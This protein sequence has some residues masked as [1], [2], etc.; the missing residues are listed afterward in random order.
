MLMLFIIK[1]MNF[2]Q[3]IL[4]IHQKTIPSK[5]QKIRKFAF[6]KCTSLTNVLFEN[7][8]S[9]YQL[10]SCAFNECSSLAEFTFPP[11]ITS[12]RS[13]VFRRCKSIKEIET[14]ATVNKIGNGAFY[15]CTSLQYVTIPSSIKAINTYELSSFFLKS[16]GSRILTAC[17]NCALYNY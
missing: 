1:I 8:S 11:S 14:T 2:S 3:K 13:Y 10:G 12:I 7:H 4:I 5:L 15:E 9:L 16:S 6:N 17:K